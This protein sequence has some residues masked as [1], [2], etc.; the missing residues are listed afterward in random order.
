MDTHEKRLGD[1]CFRGEIRKVPILFG[2]KKSAF[3]GSMFIILCQ[4]EPQE[5]KLR[6]LDALG[7][8]LLVL[9]GKQ[10]L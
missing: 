5:Y 7:K 8:F 6:E 10:L 1:I 4:S 9:Q 2:K 3:S